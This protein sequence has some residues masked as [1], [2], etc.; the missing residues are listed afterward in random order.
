MRQSPYSIVFRLVDD[1]IFIVAIAHHVREP[2]YWAG[3]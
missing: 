2:G 3:R 1:E